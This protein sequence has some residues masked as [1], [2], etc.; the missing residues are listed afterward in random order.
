VP[1]R[2]APLRQ[3]VDRL[4]AGEAVAEEAS[5]WR[6]EGRRGRGQDRS[7]RLRIE[8]GGGGVVEVRTH[9]RYN[10]LRYDDALRLLV[11]F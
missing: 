5:G 8:A 2:R 11:S 9:V 1:A 3:D 6:R 7:A 10:T 4:T